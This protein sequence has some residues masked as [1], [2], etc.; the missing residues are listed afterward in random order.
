MNGMNL[1]F[2]RKSDLS[3]TIF[4]NRSIISIKGDAKGKVDVQYEYGADEQVLKQLAQQLQ[5]S[6]TEKHHAQDSFLELP[7]SG[8]NVQNMTF[9][10]KPPNP[11]PGMMVK[12]QPN[13]LKGNIPKEIHDKGDMT[14]V[15]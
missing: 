15:Y 11:S 13:K 5:F 8:S 10:E 2:I 1:K 14:N 12:P 7:K 6:V 4:T 9:K 3:Q